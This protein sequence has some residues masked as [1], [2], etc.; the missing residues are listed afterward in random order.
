M[1]GLFVPAIIAKSHGY[2]RPVKRVH[3]PTRKNKAAQSH[4]ATFLG[5]SGTLTESGLSDG[6]ASRDQIFGRALSFPFHKNAAESRCLCFVIKR[7]ATVAGAVRLAFD[8]FGAAE[9][10]I[11]GTRIANRKTARIGG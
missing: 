5:R 1:F 11:L 10:E 2:R 3:F 8:W 9:K 7:S 6:I 4:H